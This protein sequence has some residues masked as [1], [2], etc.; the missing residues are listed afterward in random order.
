M[1]RAIV[2]D[3]L[4]PAAHEQ[5]LHE[6]TQR[7]EEELVADAIRDLGTPVD[8]PEPVSVLPEP[9]RPSALH[10]DEAVGRVPLDDLRAP[11]DRDPEEAKPVTEPGA[12]T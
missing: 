4:D 2:E 6:R 11:A 9:E 5:P 1:L 12:F 10:V 8:G 7:P 3:A